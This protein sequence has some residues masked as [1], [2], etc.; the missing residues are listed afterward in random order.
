MVHNQHRMMI[1]PGYQF[2]QLDKFC[3]INKFCRF[4]Q[5]FWGLDK[6]FLLMRVEICWRHD[7][8]LRNLSNFNIQEVL[9]LKNI[10]EARL[11]SRRYPGGG[12]P[13]T[14]Y[15]ILSTTYSGFFRPGPARPDAIHEICRPGPAR[16]RG[17]EARPGPARSY[18]QILQARARPGPG[19]ARKA[20]GPGPGLNTLV[21]I[22][23]GPPGTPWILTFK[24]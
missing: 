12:H 1:I 3:W 17:V 4:E 24:N 8:T 22:L 16:A 10:Q 13:E 14:L 23:S 9:T 19:P 7:K 6:F 2:F 15:A 5:M 20:R 21:R 11:I 18:I